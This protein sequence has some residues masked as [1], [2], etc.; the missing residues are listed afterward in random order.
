MGA[1]ERTS[2][3]SLLRGFPV[4]HQMFKRDGKVVN[5]HQN[6]QALLMELIQV[7]MLGENPDK[8]DENGHPLNWIL[9]ARAAASPQLL[10][11]R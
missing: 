7:R 1:A 3:A 6:P 8:L 11:P 9:D 5:P 4:V 10:W 2:R